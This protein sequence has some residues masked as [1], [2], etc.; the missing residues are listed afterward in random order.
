VGFGEVVG[1]GSLWGRFGCFMGA[2]IVFWVLGVVGFL[3]SV[4]WAGWVIPVYTLGVLRGTLRF[5][6]K[7]FLLIKKKKK[8]TSSYSF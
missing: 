7:L 6:I 2:S 4:L 3:G 1:L 5:F 8:Q